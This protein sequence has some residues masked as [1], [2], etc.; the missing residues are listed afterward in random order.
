MGE[1]HDTLATDIGDYIMMRIR[2]EDNDWKQVFSTSISRIGDWDWPR[3]D[4]VCKDENNNDTYALEF[5]PPKQSKRE[6]L[7]GLGQA[8]A[9]LQ[10]HTYSG[11]IVPRVCEDNFRIS[12]FIKDTLTSDEFRDVPISLIAYDQST[13]NK[14]VGKSIELMKGISSIR[15]SRIKT[16]S[17]NNRTYWCWWRDASNYEMFNLLELSDKYRNVSGDIYTGKVYPEFYELLVTGGTKQWD[18]SPREKTRSDASFKSEKQNYKIPLFQL[19][20]WNQSE[21]R[22]TVKG[23]KLLILGKLYGPDSREFIDYLTYLLLVD[24]KHLDLI[25][26]VEKFQKLYQNWMPET[27][28]KYLVMLEDYLEDKGSIGERKPSAVSTGAKESYIRDEP[29]LWNKLGL[30]ELKNTIQYFYPGEGIKFN[31]NKIT[32]LLMKDYKIA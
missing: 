32:S 18:G 8:L 24:G 27:R 10:K 21:G 16:T 25:N 19:G 26:D 6:Y 12:D 20:L 28:T 1:V 31:W 23:Y 2:K 7:T 4:Y 17:S 5:K 14:D 3:P 9:Y 11:L 30:L 22:I 29:K 15:T 13:I